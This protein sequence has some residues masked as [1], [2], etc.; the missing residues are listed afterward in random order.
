MKGS[1]V[2]AKMAGWSRAQRS[3]QCSPR[4]A[5]PAE[6]ATPRRTVSCLFQSVRRTHWSLLVCHRCARGRYG[7]QPDCLSL[8][9]HPVLS[10]RP[11]TGIGPLDERCASGQDASLIVVSSRAVMLKVAG[12]RAAGQHDRCSPLQPDYL[13]RSTQGRSRDRRGEGRTRTVCGASARA[14]WLC[15]AMGSYDVPAASPRGPLVATRP[16]PCR[17]MGTR[18][19]GR[20]WIRRERWASPRF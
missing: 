18:E 16:A 4:T 10:P 3:N 11:I 1:S 8:Y 15:R 6:P 14:R 9:R 20:A 19:S 2:T 17:K 5:G 7:C 13:V 12:D